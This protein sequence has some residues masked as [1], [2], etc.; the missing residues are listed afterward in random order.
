MILADVFIDRAKSSKSAF[1]P[2]ISNADILFMQ[3]PMA[4]VRDPQKLVLGFAQQEKLKNQ[5]LIDLG[6]T[7][8]T[9]RRKA[10]GTTSHASDFF[11]T[12]EYET[13]NDQYAKG[14]SDL[15]ARLNYR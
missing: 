11:D 2:Q 7:Y 14:F 3:A 8:G 4:S 12:P 10:R 9:W 15:N 1:G 5:Q 13:L 6:K